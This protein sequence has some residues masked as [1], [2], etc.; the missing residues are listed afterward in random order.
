LIDKHQ[1]RSILFDLDGTFADTA[2]DLAAALNAVLAR[3]GKATLPYEIIRP[4]ASHGGIALIKLGFGIEENHD[5]FESLR[6]EFLD[7]YQE[8]LCRETR[9]FPGIHELLNHIE[10]SGQNWGIVT[11]KPAFLTDPLMLTLGFDARAACIISGDTLPTRK[12]HPAPMLLACGQA[13]STPEQ[14]LYIGDARRDIEA[15]RNA[16]MLTAL[17]NWGYI[18]QDDRPGQWGADL[19]FTNPGELLDW[20]R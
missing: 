2:P 10:S 11:N 6:Q 13:G 5:H 19:Q 12:P 17:A 8:N 3:H 18:G 14:C 20:L 9:V 15:G 7:Y 16:G 1:L 4:V